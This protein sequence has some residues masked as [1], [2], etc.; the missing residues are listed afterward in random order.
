MAKYLA[1]H[2]NLG[3]ISLL[4]EK[5]F[6][7]VFGILIGIA[8]GFLLVS[9]GL[10]STTVLPQEVI[11]ALL[12]YGLTEDNVIIN[13]LRLPRIL[14]AFLVGVAL[15]VSGSILQGLI[16]NPLASP[17]VVGITGGASLGAI[18]FMFFLGG[19]ISIKWLPVAAIA[20][21][22]IIA[23]LIYLLAWNKGVTPVRL[24]LVGI[25]ISSLMSAATSFMIVLNPG[26][27]K[28]DAYIW[29][30]GS[31]YAAS[32]ENVQVLALWL[33]VLLPL[34]W[35]LT[36]ILNIHELGDHIATGLGA[37]VERER[38]LLLFVSVALAG[39]AV[40]VAGAVSFVGL[41]APHIAR[42]LVGRSFGA[43][44]PTSAVVGGLI[45][46]L[47]DLIA[48]TVFLPYDVPCGVFTAGIGAPFFIYLLY[49][50]RNQ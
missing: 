8:L 7:K 17:D 27:T 10:G 33:A 3:K 2:S 42:K 18:S 34:A 16:R 30:T 48:R 50:N 26:Y 44:I 6:L 45:V 39:V 14:A 47:A 25:G 31:L 36:R 40:S 29:L 28:T 13:T 12:G 11:K 37:S 46:L 4:I 43:I 38:F 41:I 9:I 32:W 23:L 35:F 49:R 19:T 22:W 1:F 20:G 15:A 21:A 5:R 24:V